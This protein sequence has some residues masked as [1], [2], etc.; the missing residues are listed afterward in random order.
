[1]APAARA[2]EPVA[3]ADE[4]VEFRGAV[5]GCEVEMDGDGDGASYR[6]VGAVLDV[7]ES[8]LSE[9]ALK[10]TTALLT[11]AQRIARGGSG[12]GAGGPDQKNTGSR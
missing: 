5:G 12:A 4:P 11:E 8:R 6:L 9:A 1:M 3:E 7:T 10:E 2:D